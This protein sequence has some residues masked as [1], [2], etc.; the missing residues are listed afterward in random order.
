MQPRHLCRPFQSFE[1]GRYLLKLS[2]ALTGRRTPGD[3]AAR[4]LL[5][6]LWCKTC[7]ESSRLFFS[8]YHSRTRQNLLR[9]TKRI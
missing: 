9:S 5:T 8:S 6:L 7:R 1:C 2:F 4:V 3:Y